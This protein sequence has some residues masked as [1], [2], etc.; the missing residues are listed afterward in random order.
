MYQKQCRLFLEECKRLGIP[1]FVTET[2]R[3]QERQEWLY[4]QGRTR[5]GKVVTSTRRSNHSTGYAWDIACT[6]PQKLYDSTIIAK[7][8]EVAKKQGIEW[9]GTWKTKDMPHFQVSKGWQQ[10][11]T[12]VHP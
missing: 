7:A 6:P 4:A 3:T 10:K 8:G 2:L 12:T 9:G 11:R 1:I 5:T